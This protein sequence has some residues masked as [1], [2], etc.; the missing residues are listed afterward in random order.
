[1]T[2]WILPLFNIRS[3]HL[4]HSI[5]TCSQQRDNVFELKDWQRVLQKTQAFPL[6]NCLTDCISIYVKELKLTS[7]FSLMTTP[8][9]MKSVQQESRHPSIKLWTKRSPDSL[10]LSFWIIILFNL[11]T[12][13][14]AK[15]VE[16]CFDGSREGKF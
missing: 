2:R 16:F 6:S 7:E 14:A 1:M 10:R 8:V 9:Q 5:F 12:F 13:D 11:Q 3:L 15:A 4:R